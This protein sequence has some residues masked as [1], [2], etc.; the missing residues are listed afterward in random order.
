LTVIQILLIK[1]LKT[2]VVMS[3]YGGTAF[4]FEQ[5]VQGTQC[6]KQVLKKSSSH[7]VIRVILKTYSLFKHNFAYDI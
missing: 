4:L 3:R 1:H 6:K 7:Y 5:I 2:F